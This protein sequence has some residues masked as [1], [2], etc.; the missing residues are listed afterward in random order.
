LASVSTQ[1][2]RRTNI[3]ATLWGWVFALTLPLTLT[4]AEI[5]R[6]ISAPTS[7]APVL[8]RQVVEGD[9]LPVTLSWLAQ[10]TAEGEPSVRLRWLVPS[11]PALIELAGSLDTEGWHGILEEILPP[12]LPGSWIADTLRAL[13]VW[14]EQER[15]IPQVSYDLTRLKS[16]ALS[17]HGMEALRIAFESLPTCDAAAVQRWLAAPEPKPTQPGRRACSMPDPL[18]EEH[19]Y[20]YAG[21]VPETLGRMQDEFTL[22]Q[23]VNPIATADVEMAFLDVR[24]WVRRAQ[25]AGRLAPLFSLTLLLGILLLSA[26]SL[27]ELARA[28]TLWLATGGLLTAALAMLSGEALRRA[29]LPL[30]AQSTASPEMLLAGSQA[31][32]AVSAQLVGPLL[33]RGAAAV[34]LALALRAYE[35]MPRRQAREP[36]PVTEI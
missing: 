15:P 36:L 12:D 21:T 7:L 28:W 13:P 10:P 29:V 25:I 32:R 4:G 3:A 1:A 2:T 19:F 9:L 26:R 11:H 30:G 27:A 18:R 23:A 31:L 24:F 5:A 34:I 17:S 33:V 22:E 35:R 6:L 20:A 16:R 8:T 14:L